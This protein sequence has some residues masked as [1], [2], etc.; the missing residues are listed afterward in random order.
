MT[1]KGVTIGD[2]FINPNSNKTK[3]VSTVIDFVEHKSLIKNEITGYSCWAE[4]E[5]V[6]QKIKYEVAFTT[7]LRNKI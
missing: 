5:I 1:I 6:G 4:N 7:A 2:K 3:R